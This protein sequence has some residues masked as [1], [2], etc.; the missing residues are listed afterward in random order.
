MQKELKKELKILEAKLE[1]LENESEP[2]AT[3]EPGKH[4]ST[5]VAFLRQA[6]EGKEKDLECPVRTSFFCLFSFLA[7]SCCRLLSPAH[8]SPLF[9]LAWPSPLY[10]VASRSTPSSSCQ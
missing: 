4:N 6:I 5:M 1:G 7:F 9:L 10:Q 8:P 3:A 2:L